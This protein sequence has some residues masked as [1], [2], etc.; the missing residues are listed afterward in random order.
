VIDMDKFE[1]KCK[2]CGSIIVPTA[3]MFY[4][5]GSTEYDF[6]DGVM[7]EFKC[8]CGEEEEIEIEN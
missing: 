8:Q 2:K 1:T 4:N 5:I 3:S 6:P 7:I